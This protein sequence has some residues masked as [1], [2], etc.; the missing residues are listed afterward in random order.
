MTRV[1]VRPTAKTRKRRRQRRIITLSVYVVIVFALAWYFE[2]QGTTTVIFVRHADIDRAMAES[3]DT[4]L[5]SAGFARAEK[6]ADFLDNVDVVAGVNAIYVSPAKRTQQT[7]APLAKRL[8]I[9][10]E[11]AD[12][13]DVVG[14]MNTLL[15]DHK[16][17]IV[18]VV[19]H[20][21]VIAPLVEE[22]HGSKN[23]AEFAPDEYNR[24]Y[25]VTIPWWG[26]VKTLEV[27]YTEW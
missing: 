6:L 12:H 3:S 2:S 11:V 25:I 20:S 5:N 4:P 9:E 26:K 1:Q 10:P 19:S 27:P 24:M 21:D 16:R 7:A 17:E 8:D 14:F 13:D 18:L 22:L 23:I 15:F